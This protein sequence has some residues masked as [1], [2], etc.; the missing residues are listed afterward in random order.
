MKMRTLLY[1][2]HLPHV[3]AIAAAAQGAVTSAALGLDE[4]AAATIAPAIPAA[5]PIAE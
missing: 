4:E 1:A 3:A 5:A 2:L